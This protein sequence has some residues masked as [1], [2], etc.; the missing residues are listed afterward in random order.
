MAA[1]TSTQPLSPNVACEYGAACKQDDQGVWHIGN[2]VT[3][4]DFDEA[5]ADLI[6]SGAKPMTAGKNEAY[7]RL[8]SEGF[9]DPVRRDHTPVTKQ[10]Y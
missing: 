4:Q 8:Q 9:A 2:G 5:L 6:A 7:A 1:L 10:D 3:Q